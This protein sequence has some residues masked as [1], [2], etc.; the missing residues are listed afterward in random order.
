MNPFENE[1]NKTPATKSPTPSETHKQMNRTFNVRS[2]GK[3][4][5]NQFT[6][7][8]NPSSGDKLSL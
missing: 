1:R 6:Q 8:A 7:Q 4:S 5:P 2:H 3:R